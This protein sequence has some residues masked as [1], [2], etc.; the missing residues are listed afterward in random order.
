M[1]QIRKFALG[2]ISACVVAMSPMSATAGTIQL[3][4]IL[5][6]SGSIGAGNWNTIVDGLSSV[7][8]TSLLVGIHSH[9][10]SEDWVSPLCAAPA[11][12]PTFLS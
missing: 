1:S 9:P 7:D 11:S 12:R 2:A 3:G 8:A 10:E 6:R 4:F 5:D